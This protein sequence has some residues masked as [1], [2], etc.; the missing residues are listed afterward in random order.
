MAI[1]ALIG[2]FVLSL[3]QRNEANNGEYAGSK[4]SSQPYLITVRSSQPLLC[5]KATS[6]RTVSPLTVC[7]SHK[8]GSSW[9]LVFDSELDW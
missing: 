9:D 8:P 4:H 6:V 1:K 7:P 5:G 2:L 3:V